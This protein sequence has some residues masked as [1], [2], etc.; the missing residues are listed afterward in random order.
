MPAPSEGRR[1]FTILA[2]AL[3][4]VLLFSLPIYPQTRVY[5]TIERDK[6]SN[7][8]VDTSRVPLIVKLFPSP[9]RIGAY[10]I[11]I[12][13]SKD[14]TQVFSGQIQKVPSGEYIF[15]WVDGGTPSQGIYHIIVRL[16]TDSIEKD[17]YSLDV[18]IG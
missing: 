11:K 3:F 9:Q 16:F 15:V 17:V 4:M 2:I 12:E 18:K 1:P 6:I 5:V 13:I 10:T 14:T 7:V 8:S